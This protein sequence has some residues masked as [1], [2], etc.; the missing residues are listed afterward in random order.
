MP[1]RSAQTNLIGAAGEYYVAA[2]LS[3][4]GWLA[5][6]TIKNSPDVDVLA[7][8]PPPGR[9]SVVIQ[10]KTTTKSHWVL[11]TPPQE[12][13]RR[14]DEFFVLVRIKGERERP[15]FYVVPAW[16]M[17]RVV[18]WHRTEFEH[19]QKRSP[20][21][22]TVRRGWIAQFH[23]A[24]HLLRDDSQAEALLEDTYRRE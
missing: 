5:T 16:L 23:E 3:R 7:V 17:D 20:S 24:W 22:N 12:S 11:R 4:A 18:R 8:E 21:V 1:G 15:D 14:P 13:E 6:M 9:R 19:R 10:V 2:E